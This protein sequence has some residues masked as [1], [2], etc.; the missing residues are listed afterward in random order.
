[1]AA[2]AGKR[3][4]VDDPTFYVRQH[5]LDFLNREP[6]GA[7]LSFWVAQITSCNG[8]SV[9]IDNKRQNVSAAYFLSREFQ[10]TGFFVI[11]VQRAAFGHLSQDAAKRITYQQFITD[12]QAVGQGFI[13]GKSGA[14]TILDQNKT[15]YV[16]A[17]AGSANFLLQYPTTLS[18][19][20]FVD[21]LFTTAGVTPT[22][23][24]RQAAISAFG[25]G[26]TA[27]RAAALRSVAETDSMKNAEFNPAFV[28]MQY[29]GYLRRNPTDAPDNNNVG[30]QFWLGKLTQFNGNY[31][32]SQMVRSFIVSTEYRRR[33]GQQ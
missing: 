32:G 29:F 24:E 31:I 6:D 7:G 10:E 16:Q 19:S 27:G 33:F 8:D 1:M 20:A 3:D 25:S 18:A 23:A 9:C 2:L 17:V 14:D 21:A 11:R 5:Y 13:D 12:S 30:Y 15:A 26:D 28:L 4:G 22:S